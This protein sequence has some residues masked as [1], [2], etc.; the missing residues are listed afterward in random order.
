MWAIILGVL[1][2][3]G[4]LRKFIMPLTN[5]EARLT[6]GWNHAAEVSVVCRKLA[7][8]LG[9][10]WCGC[11]GLKVGYRSHMFPCYHFV[12]TTLVRGL[13]QLVVYSVAD[14]WSSASL[15]RCST[16]SCVEDVSKLETNSCVEVPKIKCSDVVVI[17]LDLLHKSYMLPF[18][19]KP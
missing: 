19:S 14:S 3:F 12:L 9:P 16:G 7:V 4:L 1:F 17:S 2:K 13:L 11:L 5:P 6:S 10:R 18:F 15:L 8:A